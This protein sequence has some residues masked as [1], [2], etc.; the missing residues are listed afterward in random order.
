[1]DLLKSSYCYKSK[2]NSK[3]LQPYKLD[4]ELENALNGLSGYELTLGYDKTTDYLRSTLQ[5]RWNRKKVYKHMR[6]MK[7]LQPK[8][9]KRR[10]RKNKRLAISSPIKSNIRWEA[11]LAIV[12]TAIGNVY[13]FVV[14]DVY[15]KEALAGNVSLSANSLEAITS[16]KEATKKRFGDKKPVELQ[17][18][19]RVD[20]GCQYT[21]AAFEEAAISMSIDLEYCA[22]QTP[23]DKPYVESFIGCYKQDEVY[24]KYYESFFEAYEGWINYMHWYNNYRPHGSLKNMSPVAFRESKLSSILV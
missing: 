23:N 1:M 14:I 6:E 20:R 3:R 17:V 10:W 22:V 12:P 24:R 9:I 2:P 13:L 4:P 8:N 5:R 19:L 18:T 7:L 15:D 21:S 16:L 11:D